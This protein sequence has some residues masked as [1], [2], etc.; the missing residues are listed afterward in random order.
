MTTTAEGQQAWC[1]QLVERFQQR[2]DAVKKRPM[3]P[4][5]GLSRQQWIEETRQAYMDYAIIA[6]AIAS[7]KDGILVMKVDLRPQ[8]ERE[9]SVNIKGDDRG[10]I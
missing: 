5:E 9:T 8:G 3:P 2:A 6:D 7:L 10:H 4:L 1:E